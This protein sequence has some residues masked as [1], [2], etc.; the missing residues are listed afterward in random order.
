VVVE[1]LVREDG[2]NGCIACVA[3]KRLVCLMDDDL[4][5][6]STKKCRCLSIGIIPTQ[7]RN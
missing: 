1:L 5:S 2:L 3:E 4:G 7:G 6:F